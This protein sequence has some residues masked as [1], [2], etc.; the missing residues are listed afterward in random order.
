MPRRK[1]ALIKELPLSVNELTVFQGQPDRQDNPQ[2]DSL[3]D[4]ID[5]TNLNYTTIDGYTS[6]L[7]ASSR[8]SK[9][10]ECYKELNFKYEM[11]G[12]Y[13]KCTD[14]IRLNYQILNENNVVADSE[15]KTAYVDKSSEYLE[16]I[17]SD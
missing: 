13:E 7:I 8:N 2:A 5:E 16:N 9:S 12:R 3:Y 17:S 4:F 14:I 10:T 15:V 11:L 6:E 1:T